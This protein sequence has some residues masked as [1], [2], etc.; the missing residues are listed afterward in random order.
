[1]CVCVW[2]C[3]VYVYYQETE[4]QCVL[5]WCSQKSPQNVKYND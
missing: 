4:N 1:M 2:V 5:I 3:V